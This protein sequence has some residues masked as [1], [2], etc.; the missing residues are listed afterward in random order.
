MVVFN[1]GNAVLCFVVFASEGGTI[2]IAGF[3]LSGSF[4]RGWCFADEM[5]VSGL[6]ESGSVDHGV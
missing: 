3:E 1:V 2:I 4:D 6:D 5:L